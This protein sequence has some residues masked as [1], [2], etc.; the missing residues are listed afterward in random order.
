D[1]Y[2]RESI[3]SILNQTYKNFEFIVINDGSTDNSSN[4]IKDY[5][6]KDYRIKIINQPNSGIVRAL[7]RG[8]FEAKGEWVFRMDGDDIASPCRFDIQIE[9]IKKNSSLVL[10]GGACQQINSEGIPIKINKYPNKHNK[11]VNILESG[12]AFFPHPTA[13]F[14]RDVVVKLGGYREHFRHAEDIDL[15]LRL[16]NV[17]KFTCCKDVVL[18]LRKHRENIS[19]M[20]NGRIQQVRAMAARVCYFRRKYGLLESKL[21][22]GTYWKKFLAWVEERMDI[23][24][25]F[26]Q[27]RELQILKNIW[28]S[29]FSTNRL[30]RTC[31]LLKKLTKS[32]FARKAVYSRFQKDN[33]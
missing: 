16:I 24:G 23:A 13:C 5:A 25:Y 8:L 21:F 6:N 1:K 7:N 17:G 20:D 2:I 33:F 12:K 15:W 30:I 3:E 31:V 27:M 28:Y 14:R 26:Q 32:Q 9:T 29:N 19:K 18:K 11:L 10:I 4:I 22:T